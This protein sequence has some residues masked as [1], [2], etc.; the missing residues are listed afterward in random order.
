[1]LLDDAGIPR[2]SPGASRRRTQQEARVLTSTTNVI[3]GR[4]VREYLGVVS[5]ETILGANV[6]RDIGAQIRNITGGRAAGYEKE[7][8][9]GRESALAEMQEEAQKLGADAVIGVDIDYETVGGSM[10]M[11]TA[12]GTAVKLG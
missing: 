5:G 4:P 6:F 12:S 8:R 9:N 3:E 11:V 2:L 1:L 7:L 10:L